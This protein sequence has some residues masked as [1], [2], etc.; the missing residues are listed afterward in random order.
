MVADIEFL[1]SGDPAI[2]WQTMR[3][4][5]GEPERVWQDERSLLATEGWGGQFLAARNPDGSWLRGRWTDTVWTLATLVELGVPLCIDEA[6]IAFENVVSR[7]MPAG[8]TVSPEFL[9]TNMDL[10]HL[11]FW[12]RIGSTYLPTDPRLKPLAEIVLGLQFADGGWNCRIRTKPKTTHSSF[13]TT[14]NVLEGLRVAASIG[15]VEANVFNDAEA[16]AIEFLL[17]HHLYRSDRTGEVISER[18]LELSFP[19]YWHYT[20]LRGLDCIRETPFIRDERLLDPIGV[21]E[22]RARPNGRWPVEKRI[23]GDTFFHMEKVGQ[24][25]RWN[26]LRALR[27]LKAAGRL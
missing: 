15:A 22:S 2:R 8:E 3:D 18:F 17:Q 24:D 25:S 27:V 5:L 13:H 9:K 14:L 10:C 23:P 6:A 4:H 16:R 12:L 20:I 11:G 26:T 7:H 19:S 21:L 1:L